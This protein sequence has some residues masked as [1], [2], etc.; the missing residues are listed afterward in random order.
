MLR[1]QRSTNGEVVFTLSGQL[2][3][4]AVVEMETLINSEKK[5]YRLILDLKDLTLANEAAVRFLVR[6]E[7]NGITL[8][9]CPAYV[10]EWINAQRRES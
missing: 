1:I 8:K 10:R 4:E 6:C 5:G 3:E 7:A 9:N 2:D